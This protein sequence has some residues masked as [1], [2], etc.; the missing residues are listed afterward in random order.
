[1]R[2][3]ET[4]RI[5]IRMG[6]SEDRGAKTMDYITIY[7]YIF[8]VIIGTSNALESLVDTEKGLLDEL[9]ELEEPTCGAAF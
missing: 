2:P 1:L 4:R 8:K 7:L 9:D 3:D 6:L 5:S